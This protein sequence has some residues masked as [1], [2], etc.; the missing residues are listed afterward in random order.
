MRLTETLARCLS[1]PS[2]PT[3]IGVR[4]SFDVLKASRHSP[5]DLVVY[6]E[7]RQ[8][9]RTFVTVGLVRAEP[10]PGT[11]PGTLLVFSN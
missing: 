9:E 4:G 11:L 1:A 7:W 6:S 8:A 5:A 2:W 3:A 10:A